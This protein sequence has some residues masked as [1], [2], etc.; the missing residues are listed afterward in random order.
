LI[1]QLTQDEDERQ[2]LWLD[3]LNGTPLNS[4]NKRLGQFFIQKKLDDEEVKK[5]LW[6]L[7]KKTSSDDFSKFLNCFSNY[8]RSIMFCLMVGLSVPEIAEYKGICQVRVRQT[9]SAIR[10]NSSWKEFYGTK[11]EPN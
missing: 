10:Y 7:I 6:Q 2:E 11:K 4:L 8:E 3:Y 5:T 9:I 1:N